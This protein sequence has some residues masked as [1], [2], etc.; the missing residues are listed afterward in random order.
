MTTTK[1]RPIIF[2]GPMVK[3]IL[4]GRKTMTRRV[5][6]PQPRCNQFGSRAPYDLEC[7]LT[8][9]VFGWGFQDD[10]DN[11]WKFP[12]GRVGTRLWVREAWRECGSQMQAEGPPIIW[13]SSEVVFKADDPTDGPWRSP[14]HMPRLAS[15]LTLEITG[16]RVERLHQITEA[17]VLAEGIGPE[18]LEKNRKFFHKDDVAGVTF[19]EFWNAI[20]GKRHPWSSNPWVWVLSFKVIKEGVNQ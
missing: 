17:D 9:N 11:F 1:E 14:I 20:N 19:G 13:R 5:I 15:R 6:N 4:E 16:V 12:Y 18:H 2:S 8:G 10:N 3:A 7:P